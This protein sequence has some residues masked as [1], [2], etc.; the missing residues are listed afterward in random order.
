[1]LGKLSR[2]SRREHWRGGRKRT[3]LVTAIKERDRNRRYRNLKASTKAKSA[4]RRE[5]MEI[6]RARGSKR[7]RHMH[8]EREPRGQ[9]G[10]L[11]K[12]KIIKMLRI[13]NK[14]YGD[15]NI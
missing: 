11:N 14:L 15:C 8:Q 9:T 4:S 1:M 3:K 12:L 13:A 6:V 7:G 10:T 5:D 2:R